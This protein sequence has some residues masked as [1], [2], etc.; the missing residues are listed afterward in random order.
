MNTCC[1]KCR[2]VDSHDP[3]NAGLWHCSNP[4]CE[5]HKQFERLSKS[6]W[7]EPQ[8]TPRE[9]AYETLGRLNEEVDKRRIDMMDKDAFEVFSTQATPEWV[10]E[11]REEIAGSMTSIEAQNHLV[12]FVKDLLAREKK[13][14]L[15]EVELLGKKYKG[16]GLQVSRDGA[17][18][19]FADEVLKLLD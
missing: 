7:V 16:D 9:S 1:R 4:T 6:V 5:C 13:L 18:K 8:A 2:Q 12:G 14:L 19:M 11:L 10:K 15:E 17:F 3:G